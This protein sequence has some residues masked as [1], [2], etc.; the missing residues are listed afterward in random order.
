MSEEQLGLLLASPTATTISEGALIRA[1]LDNVADALITFDE[2]GQIIACNPAAERLFGYRAS[3]VVGAALTMLFAQAYVGEPFLG[4]VRPQ[5][6]NAPDRRSGSDRNAGFRRERDCRRRDGTCFPAELH[7]SSMPLSTGLWYVASVHDLSEQRAAEAAL[8]HQAGVLRDQAELLDLSHDAIIVCDLLGSI[9]F[10]NPAAATL[11]GWSRDEVP[12][13]DI[14]ELLQTRFPDALAA[15][16]DELLRTERWEGVLRQARRDGT[17]VIVETR[18]ALRR[19]T[20]GQPTSIVMINRDITARQRAELKV[21]VTLKELERQYREA[22]RA[23]GAANAILNAT[24]EAIVLVA[25]DKRLLSINRSFANIFGIAPPE[26]IGRSFDDL[27]AQVR[28]AFADPQAF[29]ALVAGSA[30]DDERQFTAHVAQAQPVAR[31]LHLFSAPV[32]SDDGVHLGRL[33]VFRDVT[34]ERPVPLGG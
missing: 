19:D 7:V 14:H 11:Y 24:S 2:A 4:T 23:G 6:A 10:W 15:A 33:Y 8:A 3:E 27:G 5:V 13:R 28:Q 21:Q 20:Q 25:P 30:G 16:L 17:G 9:T 18:W 1:V 32:W 12:D 22:D 26:L 34:H 31:E 29:S